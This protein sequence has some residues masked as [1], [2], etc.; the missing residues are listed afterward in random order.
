MHQVSNLAHRV[1]KRANTSACRSPAGPLP[2]RGF[3]R[4]AP[5]P[6][7]AWGRGGRRG[8]R[9]IVR[10]AALVCRGRRSG[11]AAMRVGRHGNRAHSLAK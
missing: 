4:A 5:P 2:A 9:P 1:V 3:A 7:T 8:L 10:G 11:T 6:K